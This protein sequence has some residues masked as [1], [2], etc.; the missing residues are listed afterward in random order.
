MLGDSRLEDAIDNALEICRTPETRDLAL[1]GR[2]RMERGLQR[3]ER[4]MD[5]APRKILLGQKHASNLLLKPVEIMTSLFSI[6]QPITWLLER[7]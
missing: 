1:E 3:F 5:Q 4:E 2:L 7:I 6:K